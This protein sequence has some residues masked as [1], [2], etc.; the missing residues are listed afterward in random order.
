M[1]RLRFYAGRIFFDVISEAGLI[2]ADNT[3]TI[4]LPDLDISHYRKS[5]LGCRGI[6]Y[7]LSYP[8]EYHFFLRALLRAGMHFNYELAL[9]MVGC[10]AEIERF[11]QILNDIKVE[12]DR[13]GLT[14]RPPLI[15]TVV[16]VPLKKARTIIFWELA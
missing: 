1:Q 13:E 12:L 15:G 10:V 11:K 2:S 7:C 8:E 9:P 16:E 6:R 3:V 14:H 4:L 5:D